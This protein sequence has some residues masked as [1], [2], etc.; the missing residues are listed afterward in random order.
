[1]KILLVE[2]HADT[3]RVM[4]KLLVME[5]HEVHSAGDKASAITISSQVEFDLV[6][7]DIGLPDGTGLE[8]MQALRAVRPIRGVALTGFGQENVEKSIAAGFAAHLTKPIDLSELKK[9]IRSLSG[10]GETTSL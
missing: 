8:L 9:T 7:S 4:S 5:G 2:D 3:A 10:P 6:I 1:M